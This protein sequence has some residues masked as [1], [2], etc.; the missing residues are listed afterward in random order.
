MELIIFLHHSNK[1]QKMKKTILTLGVIA[2]STVSFGQKLKL[3]E[4]AV[5]YKGI[6]P[7]WMMNPEALEPSK[8]AIKEA[9]TAIDE[10]YQEYVDKG[11]AQNLKK[12]KDQGKLFYYRGVIYL[13]YPMIMGMAKD[14]EAM[15]DIEAN[16]ETYGEIPFQALKK[17]Q[18]LTTYYD[19]DISQKMNMYRGLALQG[20]NAMFNEGEYEEAFAMYAGA[21]EMSDVIDY[22]DTIAM[23][24]AGLSADK[25]DNYDEAIKYYGMAA[26]NNYGGADIYRNII[27]VINRK[28]EGPSEEALTYIE[29]AKEKYPG[30]INIIIEEFNYHN[31]QGNSDAAQAALQAAIDK[32]PKNPIFHYSIGATFDEMANAKHDEGMH[33]EART[34][35][36]RAVEAYKTAIELDPK[37]ADAYYNMG[38][39]YNNESYNLTEELKSI[40]D[41]KIQDEKLKES[42]EL[43]K[44]AIPYLEKSNELTPTDVSTLKLLKSIYF[45]LEMNPE[46]EVVVGK[47]KE[48]GQ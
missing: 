33:D 5:A 36:D 6:S 25:I 29:K 44:E 20:G 2:L 41:V 28:N 9:K 14:E 18:E 42:R 4:A 22:K 34:Y 47:L 15:K 26:E 48:L 1:L 11:D 27:Q 23:F 43:L 24:N 38:V 45:T 10:A 39:L 21:V 3:T 35:V 37:Y 17:C 13:E 7:M 40:E 32:D 30:N 16:Q 31:S 12:T 46:Y 19:D 8:I